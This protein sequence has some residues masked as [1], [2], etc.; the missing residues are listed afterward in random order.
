MKPFV[1]TVILLAVLAVVVVLFIKTQKKENSNFDEI[2]KKIK[3][4]IRNI[5]PSKDSSAKN[6]DKTATF[7]PPKKPDVQKIDNKPNPKE[8]EN[9]QNA[10]DNYKT[11]VPVELNVEFG[12]F[13]ASAPKK[14][15]DR[16][17]NKITFSKNHGVCN[18]YNSD[19]GSGAVVVIGRDN[20]RPAG[21]C[22]GTEF[23][24][25]FNVLGPEDSYLSARH[26]FI[27]K[28]SNGYFILVNKSN[29]NPT[30]VFEKFDYD[31]KIHEFTPVEHEINNNTIAC[32]A[33]ELKQGLTLRVEKDF[34]RISSVTNFEDKPPVKPAATNKNKNVLILDDAARNK[35]QAFTRNMYQ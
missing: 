10:H 34:V 26:L 15:D 19:T 4:S 32:S 8:A 3:K 14:D 29:S 9:I 23:E 2:E 5:N 31:E 13:D 28:D 22:E 25:E 12:T 30:T 24:K 11:R 18:V 20:G 21:L 35:N 1:V 6:E 27:G 17:F 33:E 16:F 7:V